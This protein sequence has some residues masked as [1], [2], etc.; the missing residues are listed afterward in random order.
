MREARGGAR[1]EDRPLGVY[2]HIPFCRRKCNYCAFYSAPA[3]EAAWE[4]YADALCRHIAPVSYTHLD[5]Y[6]RQARACWERSPAP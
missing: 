1:M 6:K 4:G 3:G 5:V 2:L